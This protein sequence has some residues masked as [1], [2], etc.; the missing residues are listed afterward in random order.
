[1]PFDRGNITFTIFELPEAL[2]EN[3]I[4]LFA[5]RKAGT[6]DSVNEEPQIGWVTG[7]HLLDTTIDEASAQVGGCC[8]LALRQAV[9]KIPGSL[10]N[11]LCRREEQA[12]MRANNLEY[13]SGK[14]K[15]QIKEE[16][17]EKHIQKMPPSLSGIPFVI[18]PHRRLMYVGA[19]SQAQID[20]FVDNFMQ[21]VGIEPYQLTPELILEKELKR[22]AVDVPILSLEKSV[23]PTEAHLGRDFLLY[24]WYY[25][26]SVGE[27]EHP[28]YGSF[29]VL[30]EGPLSF[31]GDGEDRGSGE[32]VVRKGESPLRSAEAK[33]A[34]SVGKKLRKAKLSLTRLNQ[35]WSGT[36]DADKFSFSSFKLPEGEQM[37]DFEIF[38]ERI[39]NLAV[40]RD[41]IV[42]YVVKFAEAM[43][44][45]NF[46][47]TRK[48]ITEWAEKRESI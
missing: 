4:E 39:E 43:S 15:R 34:L 11:A 47:N 32:T 28:E 46:E 30:I 31:E 17:I 7:H 48:A 33:A 45:E 37:N 36:F 23:T 10:L 13:V 18:E 26:E 3:F 20:L 5:A 40:F 6:L 12:Y 1:M 8:Y 16:T 25:S 29:D 24:L 41:A 44:K 14:L 38:A 42:A 35:I 22:L 9:R 21:T 2:P 19:T 27:L